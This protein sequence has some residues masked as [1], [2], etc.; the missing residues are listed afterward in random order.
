MQ[1]DFSVI[2]GPYL[3]DILDQPRALEKTLASPAV[4]ENLDRLAGSLQEGKFKT[5]VLTGMARLFTL[6]ILS[7][8]N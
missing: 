2:E 7:I 4:S 6:S 8:S 5:V 1:S 3:H